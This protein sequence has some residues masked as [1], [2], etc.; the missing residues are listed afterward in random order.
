[1]Y[2]K[3]LSEGFMATRVLARM[4]SV[5]DIAAS[6][7]FDS[8]GALSSLTT[9]AF[10]HTT[11]KSMPDERDLDRDFPNPVPAQVNNHETMHQV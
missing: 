9:E 7:L 10:D 8:P 1:M 4:K 5:S 2:R 3:S 6:F 11:S